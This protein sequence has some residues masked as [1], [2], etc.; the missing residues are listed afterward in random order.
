MNSET[1]HENPLIE[2]SVLIVGGTSGIGLATAIRAKAAGA[3]VIVLGSSAERARQVAEKHGLAGWR[4]ADITSQEAI[5]AALADIPA[6]DHLVLLAGSFVIAKVLEADIEHLSRYFDE[7][8]WGA[9][10]TLRALGDRL[11][12][13]GSVTFTSGTL[14]HRPSASGTTMFSAAL[15]AME[16][17]GRG[18]ALELAP[19]RVNTIVPGPFDTPLFDKA[20]G[21]GRTAYFESLEKVL[22]LKRV[23]SPDEAARAILFLMTNEFVTGA[24]LKIDGGISLV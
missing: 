1:F 16:A 9:I 12:V 21:G 7:R 23:G 10:H 17:L 20:L 24:N 15:A 13:D 8:V 14:S 19:R 3:E 2:R 4:A 6:V 18:L 22:P 5:N 11:A